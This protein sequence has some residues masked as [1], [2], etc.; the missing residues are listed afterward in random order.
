[1]K[2]I[3]IY[4]MALLAGGFAMSCANNELDN[5]QPEGPQAVEGNFCISA[6]ID[7]MNRTSVDEE[8]KIAW[9]TT[10]KISAWL[11]GG[12]SNAPLAWSASE[13][14]TIATFSG[15]VT[16][17]EA[18]SYAFYA[19]YPYAESY[20]DDVENVALTIPATVSQAK[21]INEVVGVSDFMF[22]SKTLTKGGNYKATF[23][24]PLALV[25]IVIDGSTSIWSDGV[26]QSLAINAP[27]SIVGDV[28][29]NL[30]TQ[31][32]APVS[33]EEGK[34]LTINFG[35]DA[36]MNAPQNAWVALNPAL[37]DGV[38]NWEFV[39]TLTN[40][41]IIKFYVAPK[42]LEAQTKYTFTFN[43]I[44]KWIARRD[45]D[46]NVTTNYAAAQSYDLVAK[47]GGRAN[48]YIIS[49]GGMY[50][51]ACDRPLQSNSSFTLSGIKAA[52][53]L[54]ATGEQSATSFTE[55]DVPVYSVSMSGSNIFFRVKPNAKGNVIIAATNES[56]EIVWTWHLWLLPQREV[57]TTTHRVRGTGWDLAGCN[58]GATS[59]NVKDVNSYGFYYQ[60]GRKDPF[61]GAGIIGSTTAAKEATHFVTHTQKY[62]FN[63]KSGLTF[64]SG[65]R[66]SAMG[67]DDLAFITKNP[68][69]FVHYHSEK[70]SGSATG[71]GKN[72]WAY[73]LSLTD[74]KA[75]WGAA[76][77]KK[78]VYDP[79]P[80]GY[81]VV[82]KSDAWYNTTTKYS[83]FTKDAADVNGY[84]FAAVHAN[85][86]GSSYYPATG[87]RNSGQLT[88]VGFA[89]YYWACNFNDTN[90]IN[91]PYALSLEPPKATDELPKATSVQ[92]QP[93][94]GYPIRCQKQ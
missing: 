58:L 8:S 25:N 15:D 73:N 5:I 23:T 78:T 71:A 69:T 91:C 61:P 18:D 30:K 55:A 45:N 66:N 19:V 16:E 53:W 68:T 64:K 54:W 88:N 90:N 21:T 1:M 85:S 62:V 51:F 89:G 14:A 48:C 40:G 28:T 50:K 86:I 3:S 9:S 81:V 57:F 49:N 84:L 17:P 46:Q 43:Q 11:E 65:I 29:A 34:T 60:W 80:A 24:H 92:G 7:E 79:C 22:A 70:V 87:Y 37:I 83:D 44:E 72:T 4:M 59:N 93:Q 67:S 47:D 31:T 39:L 94:R 38:T 10:D 27:V 56:G 74:F 36:K 26:I 63:T 75:L 52:D 76:T 77:N 42:Q 33:A 12:S 35:A 32:I 13:G 41:H 2:K 20:G 82:T 6:S